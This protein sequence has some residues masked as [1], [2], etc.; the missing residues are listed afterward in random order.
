MH[1][2]EV[3]RIRS[4]ESELCQPD[5]R[6]LSNTVKCQ[7]RGD[8]GGSPTFHYSNGKCSLCIFDRKCSLYMFDWTTLEDNVSSDETMSLQDI[9]RSLK[10]APM[11][12][13]L[14][15]ERTFQIFWCLNKIGFD[16]LFERDDFRPTGYANWWDVVRLTYTAELTPVAHPSGSPQW[17]GNVRLPQNAFLEIL[18][19]SRHVNTNTH[20]NPVTGIR[21]YLLDRPSSAILPLE[22]HSD[23]LDLVDDSSSTHFMS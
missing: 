6:T 13:Q 16:R 22:N 2:A 1:P 21:H 4:S 10:D 5:W 12:C 14:W 9:A 3:L 11:R 23:Q 8:F 18:K 20:L 7:V 19:S 17:G 15:G